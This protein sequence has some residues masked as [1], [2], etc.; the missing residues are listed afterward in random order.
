M[1][2][3]AEDIT[4]FYYKEESLDPPA[5]C[6]KY[7]LYVDNGKYMF[8]HETSERPDAYGPTTDDDITSDGTIELSAEEWK[9]AFALLKDGTVGIMPEDLPISP[10]APWAYIYWKNDRDKYRA[11]VFSSHEAKQAFEDYCR[12]LAQAER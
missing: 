3:P 6:Q 8:F 9:H 11:Y 7:R 2:I 12:A 5:F 4:D 10:A 1:N